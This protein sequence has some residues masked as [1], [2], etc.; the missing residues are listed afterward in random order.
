MPD[1]HLQA[2]PCTAVRLDRTRDGRKNQDWRTVLNMRSWIATLLTAALL[3][4]LALGCCSHHAH[5]GVACALDHDHGD[6]GHAH[7][8]HEAPPPAPA[9]LP[10]ADCGHMTCVFLAGE[11]VVS[12]DDPSPA[13]A[14][15]FPASTALC[16]ASPADRPSA[17]PLAS[18]TAAMRPHL[19]YQV[20]LI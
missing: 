9:E 8:E 3:L 14:F 17:P 19:L 4:H 2:A 18:A 7:H 20:M 13:Q 5:E 16:T 15:V 1:S 11:K 6:H 10:D 12:P